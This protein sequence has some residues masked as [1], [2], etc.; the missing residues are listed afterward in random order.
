MTHREKIQHANQI[1][2]NEIENKTNKAFLKVLGI[3]VMVAIGIYFAFLVVT[4][5]FDSNVK[6]AFQV[7][8][9]LFLLS[10][11]AYYLLYRIKGWRN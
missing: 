3:A 1:R 5:E 6:M 2:W 11:S 4:H 8:T 10:C 7:L 9:V